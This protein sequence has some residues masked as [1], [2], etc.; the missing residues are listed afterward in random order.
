M[1]WLFSEYRVQLKQQ[2][3]AEGAA[4]SQKT[5]SEAAAPP[6][7][8]T[9]APGTEPTAKSGSQQREKQGDNLPQPST[10]AAVA[11]TH[12]DMDTEKPTDFF[13]PTI[14]DM[15]TEGHSATKPG[16]AGKLGRSRLSLSATRTSPRF[17][18][19][20]STV[21]NTTA[22]VASHPH[23]SAGQPVASAFGLPARVPVGGQASEG[24]GKDMSGILTRRRLSLSKRKSEQ[25][26]MDSPTKK[27]PKMNVAGMNMIWCAL[28]DVVLLANP[29]NYKLQL[30]FLGF[31]LYAVTMTPVS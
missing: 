8:E 5:V 14:S 7:T 3:E 10:H 16:S 18:G 23:A 26:L 30:K 28:R 24:A 31:R 17:G 2:K 11:P 4:A 29:W 15:F 19:V 27:Q 25:H 6:L 21:S 9:S 1:S 12:T 13:P 22:S 20:D